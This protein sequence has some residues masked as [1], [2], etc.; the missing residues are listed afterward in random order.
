M[1][2]SQRPDLVIV[3]E[4]EKQIIIFE[5]SVPWDSNISSAHIYKVNK[6]SA[7][8]LDLQA[9]GFDTFIFCCEVSVRGQISKSNK[10]QLKTF[11][12]KSTDHPKSKFK[13]FINNISKAALLGSFT[14]FNARN[15]P[16]WNTLTP[17]SVKI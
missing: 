16:S 3:N 12:F 6:Y 8:K 13:T 1:T 10:S 9:A 17:L 2:T 4:K 14:I 5:L 15:E 11:L 7:L